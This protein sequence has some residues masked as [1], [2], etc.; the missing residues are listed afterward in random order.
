MKIG[1]ATSDSEINNCYPVMRELRPQISEE[2]FLAQ[3]RRLE[4][5]GFRLAAMRDN[6]GIV[7]VAGFRISENLAWG[8]YLYL[9]DLVTLP[10]QRSMGHGASLLAWLRTYAA[11]QGCHQLHLD[12]GIQRVEAHRFYEREG[13]TKSGFHFQQQLT[14][15][16]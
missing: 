11:K 15:G 7:A 2:A 8:R 14:S 10:T 9:D 3:V 1:L 4:T 6:K 5:G 16:F 12:S 13:M